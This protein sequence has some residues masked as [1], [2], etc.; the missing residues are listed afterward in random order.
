[1]MALIAPNSLLL[2]SSIREPDGDPWAIEQN[3]KSVKRVYDFLGAPDHVGIRLRDGGHAVSARDIE[4]YMDWLDIQFRRKQLPWE[5]RLVYDYSFDKWKKL[6]GEQIDSEQFPR[7]SSLQEGG[8]VADTATW[9][10]QRQV[11]Q[12]Q[13]RWLMGEEPPGLHGDRF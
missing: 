11:I 9:H 6:S 1:L 4:S 5:N 8:K 7:A 2:S 13:I 10:Q 3:F 12:Q